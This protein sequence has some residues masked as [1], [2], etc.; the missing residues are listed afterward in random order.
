MAWPHKTGQELGPVVRS[1]TRSHLVD[2]FNDTLEVL[3]PVQFFN[4][5]CTISESSVRYVSTTLC[6]ERG[7]KAGVLVAYPL[8]E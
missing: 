3:V 5:G 2:F 6:H 1:G 8:A 4:T 7:N